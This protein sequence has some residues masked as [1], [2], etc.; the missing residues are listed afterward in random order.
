VPR[1]K[2][3]T[4]WRSSS[5]YRVRIALARKGLEAEYVPVNLLKGEQVSDGHV[6]RNPLG[7]VPVLELDGEPFVESVAIIELLDELFPSPPLYP[8]DPWARA[9][10]RAL[11]E[12]INAGTQPFHNLATLK[13]VSDEQ[14]AR[15]AWAQHFIA[16]GLAGFEALM[17]AYEGLGVAGPYAY[18]G[19]I[20]AADVVLVPQ[21]YQAARYGVDM[22]PFPRVL[23]AVEA[24][25][26]LE[27]FA[28]AAPEA[29]P[30]AQSN[31]QSNAKG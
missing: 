5:S 14:A 29:Q 18:G 25:K 22:T 20:T 6:A 31:A 3:Y 9:R 16:R 2:L 19:T 30:D 28:K 23:R 8:K 1:I 11:V 17:A 26:A 27:D 10:V 7:Q 21:A 12:V 15:Q 4:Y 24:A 13:Q